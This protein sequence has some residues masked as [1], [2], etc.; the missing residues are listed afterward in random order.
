ME[1]SITETRSPVS[2]Q[3]RCTCGW[4]RQ[5]T[6]QQNALGRAAKV[7]AAKFQHYKETDE[8]ADA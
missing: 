7:R 2:I 5:I 6:R 8:K 3:L 1:H 4:C